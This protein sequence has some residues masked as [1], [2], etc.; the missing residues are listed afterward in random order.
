MLECFDLCGRKQTIINSKKIATN[1]NFCVVA[2]LF[3]VLNQCT[4]LNLILSKS[5]DS[6][7]LDCQA[8]RQHKFDLL[9][10]MGLLICLFHWCELFNVYF[11]LFSAVVRDGHKIFRS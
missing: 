4:G 11:I 2:F 8:V 10:L 6:L 7:I 1:T 3:E 5:I 9:V